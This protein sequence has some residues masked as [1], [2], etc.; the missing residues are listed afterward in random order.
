M[1]LHAAVL[2]AA[3][4]THSP[5]PVHRFYDKPAK[6][7]LTA[8]LS[9]AAFDMGQT[10]HNLATGGREYWMTQSCAGDIGIVLGVHAA[11]EGLAYLLHRTGHHHLERF[12]RLY[13]IQA[14]V[15]GILYSKQ[16]GAW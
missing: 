6:I 13:T 12:T 11:Q 15:R 16:H 2:A 14:H 5:A 3:F 7:E 1:I 8:S 10:C 9:L 4:V